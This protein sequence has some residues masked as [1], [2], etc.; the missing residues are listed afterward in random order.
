MGAL[1]EAAGHEVLI[2]EVAQAALDATAVHDVQVFILDIGLP[3]MDGY[4]LARRLRANV[5]TA[6]KMLIALTG[7]SQAHDRVL[8]KAAGFDHHLV[9]PVDATLLSSILTSVPDV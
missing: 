9:K 4:E 2:S 3:D 7:Y 6:N 5:K 1:L 8:S